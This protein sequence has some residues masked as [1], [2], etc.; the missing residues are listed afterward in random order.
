MKNTILRMTALSIVMLVSLS[1][2]AGAHCDT[3]DGPVV[4]AAKIALEK[5]NVTPVLRWV[6]KEYEDEVRQAF[7]KTLE[8]RKKGNDAREL[9]D[10]YFFETVV[11]LH[12]AGEG[13]PYTGLKPSGTPVE[14]IVQSADKALELGSANELTKQLTSAVEEEISKR[15]QRALETKKEADK[16][17]EAGREFVEAYV[18]FVHYTEQLFESIHKI[19]NE[20]THGKNIPHAHELH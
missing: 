6:R 7:Q 10:M 11:R 16:S 2:T 19:E 14:P 12:R 3:M 20:Q 15:F 9:A 17:I 13:E 1:M 5:G 18:E 4:K 8:V